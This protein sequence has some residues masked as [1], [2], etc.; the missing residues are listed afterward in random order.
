M[1]DSHMVNLTGTDD[2]VRCYQCGI[3]LKDFTGTDDPLKEH[4]KHS[5][6]CAFLLEH[7]GLSDLH[8]VDMKHLILDISLYG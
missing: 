7:F 4:V 1:S 6:E 2:L 5:G 8:F 3:G